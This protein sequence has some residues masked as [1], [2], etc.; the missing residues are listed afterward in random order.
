VLANTR[1]NS[2]V[3]IVAQGIANVATALFGGL[4][5]GGVIARTSTN[6]AAGAET[7]VAGMLAACIVLGGAILLSPFAGSL[8]LPSLAGVLIAISLR[9]ID[10]TAF[11]HFLR[12]A[13]RDD[14]LVMLTTLILTVAV[15]LNV[16]ISVGVIMA[17]LLF[18]HRM[19]ET[20]AHAISQGADHHVDAPP[21][22]RVVTFRGPLFFGQSALISNLMDSLGDPPSTTLVLDLAH[23]TLIDGTAIDAL[24]ELAGAA[25][26]GHCR[27]VIAGLNGQPLRAVERSGLCRRCGIDRAPHVA[28]AF[29]PAT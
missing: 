10:G 9:L 29:A 1:H 28:D 27:L 11:V 7:P 25:K 19:A 24:E 18:M 16:A 4:P 17:S 3:E 13:P 5:V 8:A 14:I 12:H 21:G 23:V 26:A 20:P 22:T 2:N 15:D 6:I